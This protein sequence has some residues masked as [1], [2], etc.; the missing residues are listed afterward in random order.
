MSGSFW[1]NPSRQTPNKLHAEK[2][3]PWSCY[4]AQWSE[5]TADILLAFASNVLAEGDL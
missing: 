3:C 5:L 1:Y 2:S 4:S